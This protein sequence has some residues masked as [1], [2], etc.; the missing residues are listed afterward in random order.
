MFCPVRVIVAVHW[1]VSVANVILWFCSVFGGFVHKPY[2]S[3][4]SYTVHILPKLLLV[5]SLSHTN[6][7]H[8]L[9]CVIHE[10]FLR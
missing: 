9:L 1:F 4:A 3:G 7:C 6:T 2:C 5:N 10:Q 8:F